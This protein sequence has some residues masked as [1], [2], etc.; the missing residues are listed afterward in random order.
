MDLGKDRPIWRFK[1]HM[2]AIYVALLAVVLL[3]VFTDILQTSQA[4]AI[5]QLVWLLVALVPLVAVLIMLSKVFK[6][7]SVLEENGA[8]LDKIAQSLEKNRSALTQ[9][10][11]STRL[12]ETAKAI[13]FRYA[14]KQSLREAVF[15]KLHQQDFDTT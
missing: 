3:T 10:S 1:W 7:L 4:G 13:V 12:S 14:D 9:I 11:Q 8:R 15:D 6:I 2:V 5:P